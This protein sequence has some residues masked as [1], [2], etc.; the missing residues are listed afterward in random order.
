MQGLQC[1]PSLIDTLRVRHTGLAVRV[2]PS[3]IAAPR[4]PLGKQPESD[5]SRRITLARRDPRSSA[6]YGAAWLVGHIGALLS[7]GLQALSVWGLGEGDGIFI[8]PAGSEPLLAPAGWVLREIR[9]AT[10][11]CSVQ[12]SCPAA[13]A[14]LVA[15]R[16]STSTVVLVANLGPSMLRL[17]VDNLPPGN[18]H[19]LD[20]SGWTAYH[21]GLRAEPWQDFRATY[22][23]HWQL[24]PHA[25]VRLA[26]R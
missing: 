9:D 7:T 2:G 4:S 1:L 23:G 5:G 14:A 22:D 6:L 13:T 19:L 20:A 8:A 15:E 16:G 17:R 11:I 24:P 10:R 12:L 26:S 18:L 3:G 21:E 25:I